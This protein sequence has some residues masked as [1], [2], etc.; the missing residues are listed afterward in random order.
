[1]QSLGNRAWGSEGTHVDSSTSKEELLRICRRKYENK[2]LP[3]TRKTHEV[4]TVTE[5][6][7]VAPVSSRRSAAGDG[8]VMTWASKCPS[9]ENVSNKPRD[10]DSFQEE[11]VSNKPRDLD[12]FLEDCLNPSGS[13]SEACSQPVDPSVLQS[14]NLDW[15]FAPTPPNTHTQNSKVASS[16]F[17]P[18]DLDWCFAPAPPSQGVVC[19]SLSGFDFDSFFD[20]CLQSSTPCEEKPLSSDKA[21]KQEKP[22]PHLSNASE[23]YQQ[24]PNPA[25]NQHTIPQPSLAGSPGM[26]F[27]SDAF[28]NDLLGGTGSNHGAVS[29]KT[30]SVVW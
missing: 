18:S 8:E 12:S 13:V 22:A 3:Q 5:H 9:K 10:W 25:P 1:M 2:P 21:A 19:R 20:E 14:S 24:V 16:S 27:D 30:A 28:F 15:C 6:T 29:L 11:N 17:R 23:N 26:K 7:S 4:A